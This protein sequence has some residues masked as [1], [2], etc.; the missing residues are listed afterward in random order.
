[1][2]KNL[3][4]C[5]KICDRFFSH[6]RSIGN[7]AGLLGQQIVWDRNIGDNEDIVFYTENFGGANQG[8]IKIAILIESPIVTPYLY[9]AFKDPTIRDRFDYIFTFSDELLSI[10]DK[11]IPYYLG[12]C[13]IKEND[14]KVHHKNRN[15]SI[16]ASGKTEFPG[17]KI[18]HDTIRQL[19]N[20]IDLVCGR[21]YQPIDN[22][23]E[24]LGDFRY[25][26]VAENAISDCYFSEKLID[27]FSTGTV[28][29][30]WGCKSLS[31]FFDVSGIIMFDTV[32]QLTGILH[33]INQSDYEKRLP[34]I[35]SNFYLSKKYR[36]CENII[37]E[38]L[39]KRISKDILTR[40]IC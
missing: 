29:I 5:F 33:T 30:Y 13:W 20:N 19:R 7:E 28:P 15:I 23:I 34:H 10:S 18:R 11:F 27:C 24:A 6:A 14:I 25:S 40:Y 8:K 22:K 17:H 1:M 12:G 32:E 26:I 31:K 2:G 9:E 3:T 21:G 16:I 36:I 37:V 35:Q 39:E 38:E 4:Y